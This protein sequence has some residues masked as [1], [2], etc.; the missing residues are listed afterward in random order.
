VSGAVQG[1]VVLGAALDA[2]EA[3]T[4][5]S[6][7]LASGQFLRHAGPAGVLC[8]DVEVAV[9]GRRTT[10]ARVL[11]HMEGAEVLTVQGALGSRPL[12]I[13]A[14]WVPRPDVPGPETARPVA[15]PSSGPDLGALLDVRLV[16][17]R[18]DDELDGAPGP[19]Q[20]M[21][22]CQRLDAGGPVTVGELAVIA[23]LA[24][25]GMSGAVGRRVTGNSVDSTLRV[26]GADQSDW[27]LLEVN[28]EAI[29][30]GYAHVH[31]RLWSERGIF[32]ATATQSLIVREPGAMGRA[33]RRNRRIVGSSPADDSTSE[34]ETVQLTAALPPRGR[35]TRRAPY[36]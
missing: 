4:G 7:I 5:R 30:D 17:G 21:A 33:V 10:Q 1:G 16:A 18:G 6:L 14:T 36:D 28:V 23:D 34:R 32:L 19:G 8:I 15:L 25:L 12:D 2:L 3:A 24:V 29:H 31:T 20:W 13:E 27:I 11:V 9:E 22:W 35:T 26:A